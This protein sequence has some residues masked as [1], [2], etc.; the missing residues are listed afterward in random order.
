MGGLVR[1]QR[2]GGVNDKGSRQSRTERKMQKMQQE[3]RENDRRRRERAEEQE[4]ELANETDEI[5]IS[6]RLKST[7]RTAGAGKTN[8]TKK[9]KRRRKHQNPTDSLQTPDEDED[10]D[11]PWAAIAR[12]RAQQ[13]P[14]A[15]IP[16]AA[17]TRGHSLIGLHDVVLA[18][19]KLTSV[20]RMKI[21]AGSAHPGT[22]RGRA[23]QIMPGLRGQAELSAAR[24][25]V[26]E[27]YR[28]MMRERRGED[29]GI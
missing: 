19:P 1:S 24:R 5:G 21:K 4:D 15:D 14:A 26:I 12:K 17:G 18:P 6:R 22:E 20:P 3:W 8:G 16:S 9:A 10:E 23:H 28:R 27:R 11:D 2:S 25:D 7:Q 13:Q 29:P